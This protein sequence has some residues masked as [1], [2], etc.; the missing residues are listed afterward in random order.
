MRKNV[1]ETHKI[2]LQNEEHL[3]HHGRWLRLIVALTAGKSPALEYSNENA[4][5]RG[6]KY[7]ALNARTFHE[8]S[9]R[10]RKC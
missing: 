3:H 4:G 7:A 9:G 8:E 1:K 2:L 6:K 10:S 5:T